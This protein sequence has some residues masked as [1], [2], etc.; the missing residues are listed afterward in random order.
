[1]DYIEKMD[2]Q[3]EEVEEIE[4]LEKHSIINNKPFTVDEYEGDTRDFLAVGSEYNDGFNQL[5]EANGLGI[6]CNV[7]KEVKEAR[8]DA[9]GVVHTKLKDR[10]DSE[11]N[12]IKSSLDKIKTEQNSQNQNITNNSSE[13]DNIKKPLR[14]LKVVCFGDSNTAL[15][16]DMF[17]YPSQ[18]AIMSWAKVINLGFGGT[19]LA[20]RTDYDEWD[21]FSF[22]SLVTRI[23]SRNYIEQEIALS[24]HNI[25]SYFSDQLNKLKDIDFNTVDYI[26]IGYGTNDLT[27]PSKLNREGDSES[28][29]I[30][31]ISYE[32]ALRLAL[33]TIGRE[34]PHIRVIT[35]TPTYRFD[36][37]TQPS[38]DSWTNSLGYGMKDYI[39]VL[40]EVTKEHHY[41][42]IDL[43]D[44]LGINIFTGFNYLREDKLHWKESTATL[45]ARIV[46][47][48]I[49]DIHQLTL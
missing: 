30:D 25:P 39:R 26:I 37:Q 10:I 14:N 32:G 33:S 23:K 43:Y 4:R 13:I 20:K 21:K 31:P 27:Q 15:N 1:M 34:F 22:H 8:Q 38:S 11:V 12:E 3:T 46:F 5:N 41:K 6:S 9:N 2:L 28:Q 49:L 42:N 45:V 48:E 19:T 29:T 36:E 18:L 47:K 40:K 24:G 7:S 16:L 35:L 17:S 44:E